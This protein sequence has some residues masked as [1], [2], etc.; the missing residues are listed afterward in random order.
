[1]EHANV[2]CWIEASNSNNLK[3]LQITR[4]QLQ[5]KGVQLSKED[6]NKKCHNLHFGKKN[7]C[8]LLQS[9]EISPLLTMLQ[10]ALQKTTRFLKY[11]ENRE[12][13]F[14]FLSFLSLRTQTTMLKLVFTCFCIS[15]FRDISWKNS[16]LWSPY[17]TFTISGLL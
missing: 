6:L 5:K 17:T 11:S 15:I 2:L 1:M 14:P 3:P 7:K 4:K 8:K 12:R 10:F 16:R 13:I 9:L